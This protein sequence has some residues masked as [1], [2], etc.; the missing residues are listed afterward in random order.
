M[1][2]PVRSYPALT[3]IGNL[4]KVL[5]VLNFVVGLLIAIGIMVVGFSG[6]E[7]DLSVFEIGRAHV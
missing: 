3:T 5:S 7:R 1:S 6:N 2:T 4:F